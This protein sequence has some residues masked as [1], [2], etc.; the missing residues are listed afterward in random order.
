MNL[1]F[2]FEE[3]NAEK[4][5]EFNEWLDQ[6]SKEPLPS[7]I[8]NLLIIYYM[9]EQNPPSLID[10]VGKRA[11]FEEIATKAFRYF[12][13]RKAYDK[14]KKLKEFIGSASDTISGIRNRLTGEYRKKFGDEERAPRDMSSRVPLL[15]KDDRTNTY[16][17]RISE[18]PSEYEYVVFGSEDISPDDKEVDWDSIDARVGIRVRTE[19][20][21]HSSYTEV[22]KTPEYKPQDSRALM[23]VVMDGTI[24]T[25]EIK[26][27]RGAK[28][29]VV[30]EPFK[31]TRFISMKDLFSR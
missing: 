19:K 3:I 6:S 17:V 24:P 23:N 27:I 13:K 4:M 8:K 30:K 31:D 26:E 15:Y 29:I 2:L 12:E 21:R 14:A 10:E 25:L 7:Q 28:R 11:T 22:L 9:N 1:N 20:D 5:S 16:V 18:S